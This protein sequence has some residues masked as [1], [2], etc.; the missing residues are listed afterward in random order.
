MVKFSTRL[1]NAQTAKV[2][3]SHRRF[4]AAAMAVL[5]G[6]HHHRGW[7]IPFVFDPRRGHAGRGKIQARRVLHPSALR[8]FVGGRRQ[9]AIP[10]ASGPEA[11]TTGAIRRG[12][13][14][15]SISPARPVFPRSEA[16]R[17]D[18]SSSASR[19]QKPPD[20]DLFAQKQIRIAAAQSVFTAVQA[21]S[22][23][24]FPSQEFPRQKPSFA[25]GQRNRHNLWKAG[26]NAF[27]IA[28]IDFHPL[29]GAMD[30]GADA[31]EFVLDPDR[32]SGAQSLPKS[33][34]A[35]G[36]GEASMHLIGWQE[37]ERPV[38]FVEF[39]MAGQ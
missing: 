30:L 15:G 33:P 27:Q 38:S 22:P 12:G 20:G 26:R 37:R 14:A 18:F 34:V 9:A 13:Q 36:S 19:S 10:D 5:G 3:W 24:A 28:G 2:V 25:G 35:S 31:I 4:A 39:V 8:Y 16:L 32:S 21:Q 11:V 6:D 1:T 7:Q 17:S 23:V 29:R